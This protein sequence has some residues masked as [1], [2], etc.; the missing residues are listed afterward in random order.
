MARRMSVT[1]RM[2]VA[3]WLS[4]TRLMGMARRMSDA[5]RQVPDVG[6]VVALGHLVF[7]GRLL[8][9]VSRRRG[10]CAGRGA[11]EGSVANSGAGAGAVWGLAV[12]AGGP[13]RGEDE[14]AGAGGE[15]EGTGSVLAWSWVG[16][17]EWE[18][19]ARGRAGRLVFAGWW[20]LV[21]ARDR[22]RGRGS[23]TEGA[24]N[25]LRW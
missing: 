2:S 16:T 25:N 7:W 19:S 12:D 20:C 23:C 3:R 17:G 5:R 13:E 15:V 6:I 1:R 9:S 22:D 4:V 10:L 14:F 18:G 11:S 24:C 8:G 21:L